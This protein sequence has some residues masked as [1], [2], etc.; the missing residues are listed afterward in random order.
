MRDSLTDPQR[1]DENGNREPG[2]E[3]RGHIYA[4]GVQDVGDYSRVGF[5]IARSTDDTYL[6][7]YGFG[8]QTYLF[9][10]AYYEAA[11]DRNYLL[12]QTVAFQGLEIADNPGTTPLVLPDISGYYETHPLNDYGLRFHLSGDAASLTTTEGPDERRLSLTG[13]ADMKI[14]TDDGQIFTPTIN[15]RQDLYAVDHVVVGGGPATFSGDV[16]RTIPQ[17]AL[18]WRYPLIRQF[19]NDSM[20]IEP[21]ML[22]VAQPY[23]HNTEEIPD[24][25]NTLIE[26]NQGQPVQP[27]PHAGLRHGGFRPARRLR[28]AQRVSLRRRRE[29]QH[30]A[31]A[32]LQLQFRHA[33]PQLDQPRQVR[34]RLHRR[35]R[36]RLRAG[37]HH[38]R[39]RHQQLDRRRRPDGDHR[40]LQQ[41]VAGALR[42]FPLAGAQ[43]VF[44]RFEGGHRQ[45]QPADGQ[46]GGLCRGPARPGAQSNGCRD[47]RHHLSQRVFQPDTQ[48]AA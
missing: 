7:R 28:R 14:V 3:L 36:L 27:E 17:A 37:R 23:D 35:L 18:E 25:D 45:R 34:L 26:L 4:D 29:H 43:P 30:A 46:L 8:D 19:G 2:H 6:R 24:E 32:G 47:G 12:A 15:V 33:L 42:R 39:F 1:L 40:Q 38:L 13:G 41:A 11:E 31:R 5:D 22:A 44:A 48:C 9:S 16:A 21:I 20:T 10:R